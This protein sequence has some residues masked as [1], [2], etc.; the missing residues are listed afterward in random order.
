MSLII[1]IE[2]RTHPTIRHLYKLFK[3]YGAISFIRGLS[4]CDFEIKYMNIV[5]AEEA[6]HE[7]DGA[8]VDDIIPNER[9]IIRVKHSDNKNV[10]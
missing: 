5:A 4:N 3:I 9:F 1:K 2:G 6:I 7:L 10:L 8:D